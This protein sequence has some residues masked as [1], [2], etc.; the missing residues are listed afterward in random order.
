MCQRHPYWIFTLQLIGKR[1]INPIVHVVEKLRLIVCRQCF[2]KKHK[3][4]FNK[5]RMISV[6]PIRHAVGF[7]LICTVRLG[8]LKIY[9]YIYTH[10]HT[11]IYNYEHDMM[12]SSHC[13]ADHWNH[14]PLF[15]WRLYS[16]P[17]WRQMT[18]NKLRVQRWSSSRSREE[19]TCPAWV[20]ASGWPA[21]KDNTRSSGEMQRQLHRK[22]ITWKC[23]NNLINV[24]QN[25]VPCL[26]A[27]HFH[28]SH[29]RHP[30]YSS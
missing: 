5:H 20:S 21:H 13:V 17:A 10:T 6:S 24:Q 27:P 4:E 22:C 12:T 16:R 28:Q 7:C 2:W 1:P 9:I 29:L 3:H 19:N 11:N 25:T 26:T 15:S 8:I 23:K 30:E 18:H 14:E